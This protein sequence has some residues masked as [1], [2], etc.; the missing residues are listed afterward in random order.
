MAWMSQFGLPF[1]RVTGAL[2][3]VPIFNNR[4][5]PGRVRIGLAVILTI[6]VAPTLPATP[7]VAPLSLPGMLMMANE[8][9]IGIMMG[10]LLL[11]VFE[12]VMFAA[13][14]IA[15]GMGLSFSIMNDPQQGISIPVLGQFLMIIVTLLF[16]AMNGHHE[17][18]K[19]VSSSFRLWPV[20]QNWLSQELI[21][22]VSG[23]L[24]ELFRGALRV[25]LPA[26]MA[27]LL[28]QVAL[29]VV[30]RAAPT[31]NLFAVGFPVFILL[32]F[33]VVLQTLPSLIPILDAMITTM[34]ERASTLLQTGG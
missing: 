15:T 34:F 20:G 9:L 30:S 3:A 8:L 26:V 11:L 27:L 1:L 19:L 31:L 6:L 23:A 16:L 22:G 18:L 32:G 29:G 28:V 14:L 25:A 4:S 33:V 17:F 24:S 21:W 2:M 13:Q 10:F 12:S 7:T 5:I